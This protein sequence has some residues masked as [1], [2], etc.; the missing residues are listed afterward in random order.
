[1]SPHKKDVVINLPK[2]YDSKKRIEK[3]IEQ[4]QRRREKE[5]N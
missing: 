5:N 4:R 2:G 3:I 1:M